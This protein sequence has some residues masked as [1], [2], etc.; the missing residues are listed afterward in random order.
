MQP[1]E[2]QVSYIIGYVFVEVRAQYS[3]DISV[4]VKLCPFLS[5]CLEGMNIC[6]GMWKQIS[7]QV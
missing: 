3:F 5:T 1:H 6:D 4:P 7:T 2:I